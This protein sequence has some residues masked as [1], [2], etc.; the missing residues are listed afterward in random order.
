MNWTTVILFITLAHA[1]PTVSS[2]PT[3]VDKPFNETTG[4]LYEYKSII[5]HTI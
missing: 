1:I 2:K 4:Q 3:V 5:E